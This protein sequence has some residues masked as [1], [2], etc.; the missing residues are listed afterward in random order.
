MID[1]DMRLDAS[2]KRLQES[3]DAA[4]QELHAAVVEKFPVGARI[5]WLFQDVHEQHG[6]VVRVSDCWWS[7]PEIVARNERTNKLVMIWL[8][9]RPMIG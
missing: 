6:V 4:R 2:I 5:T 1:P 3:V 8:H 9:M 7:E